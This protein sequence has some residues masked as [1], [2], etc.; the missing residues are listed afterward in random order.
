MEI[1]IVIRK[2]IGEKAVGVLD[3][4][5]Y[6]N[7]KNIWCGAFNGQR[8][9]QKIFEELTRKIDF[10][11]IMETG[12]YTGTT[13]EFMC[14]SSGLPVYTVE[15]DSRHYGYAKARFLINQKVSVYFGDS[16]TFLNKMTQHPK[17][18]DGVIFFYLDAHWDEDLPLLEEIRIIFN[19]W[20][21]AVVM[22]D[23]FKVPGDAGYEFDDY[24]KGKTLC[25]EYLEPLKDLKLT[26]FFPSLSAN[27]ETGEKRGCVLIAKDHGLIEK[28]RT[29][30]TLVQY[31][32]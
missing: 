30:D 31:G 18:S 8:F 6:P 2:I 14:E 23:D 27:S 26:L 9:R 20:G 25:L 19:H 16:R 1:K 17:V 11:A 22:I 24:G 32:R 12:T 10:S 3:C 29:F 7:M 15:N 28:L 4:F 21:K 5:R 13:T